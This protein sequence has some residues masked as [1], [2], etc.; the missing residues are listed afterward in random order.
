MEAFINRRFQKISDDTLK[1]FGITKMQWM[2]IGFVLDAGPSGTR[3]SDLANRLGTTLGYLTNSVNLLESRDILSRIDNNND[4]RSKLII[5]KP[6]YIEKCREIEDTL[7]D[8]LKESIYDKLDP[9][10][11]KV[12][13]KVMQK[14][15][16]I[17]DS[18]KD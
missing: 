6:T 17:N 15:T 7:R 16:I 14:I 18:T 5:V 2:I 3:L 11:F 12:Y 9:D 8:S 4:T 1:P 10:E 13:L